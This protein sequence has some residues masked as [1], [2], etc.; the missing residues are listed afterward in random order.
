MSLQ[1]EISR[2]FVDRE[3]CQTSHLG[4]NTEDLPIDLE[5]GH[6]EMDTENWNPTSWRS[7]KVA[8]VWL[9]VT[10]ADDKLMAFTRQSNTPM[11]V[12]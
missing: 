10:Q 2:R 4:S 11:R 12:I 5:P 9:Y 8:Q 3:P 7:K 6:F 1:H